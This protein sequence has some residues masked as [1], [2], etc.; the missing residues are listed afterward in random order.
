MPAPK[1]RPL[2]LIAKKIYRNQIQRNKSRQLITSLLI[3]SQ[4]NKQTAVTVPGLLL[5]LKSD[6]NWNLLQSQRRFCIYLSLE[7]AQLAVL[8]DGK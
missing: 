5:L 8:P 3:K 1:N 2:K 6:I 4:I 7:F